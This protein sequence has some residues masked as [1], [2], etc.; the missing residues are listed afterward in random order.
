VRLWLAAAL[1]GAGVAAAMLPAMGLGTLP[2]FSSMIAAT[3]LAVGLATPFAAA[4]LFL[5]ESSLAMTGQGPIPSL[6]AL[7]LLALLA[8]SGA[9]R[10]SLDHLIG[11]RIR[12]R[13]SLPDDALHIVIVGA[14]FG[15]MPARPGCG[16]C[17]CA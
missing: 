13:A 11:R 5:I 16:M 15:G 4:S 17:Q 7:S 14:G 2:R 9:G 12:R 8:V 10:Y 6:Y 1:L 3:T